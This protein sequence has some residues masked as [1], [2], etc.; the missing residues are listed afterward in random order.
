MQEGAIG[1]RRAMDNMGQ[2]AETTTDTSKTADAVLEASR[3]VASS[4]QNLSE[5]I[6]RFLQGVAAA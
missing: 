6:S 2:V 1:T 3:Q 4:T 5:R